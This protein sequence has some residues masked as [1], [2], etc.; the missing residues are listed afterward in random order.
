MSISIHDLIKNK[1]KKAPSKLGME[2]HCSHS[3]GVSTRTHSNHQQDAKPASPKS[4]RQRHLLPP[5]LV[6]VVGVLS[7]T[8]RPRK[9]CSSRIG[10]DKELLLA[11]NTI[12]CIES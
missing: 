3:K 5:V 12:L 7:R 11:V 1:N 6:T 9:T 8:V 4:E 2:G 10:R